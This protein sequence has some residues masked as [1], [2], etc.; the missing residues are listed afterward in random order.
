MGTYF[1][2]V[3]SIVV[4]LALTGTA[5]LLGG[6]TARAEQGAAVAIS[7]KDHRFQPAEIH[8]PAN[9]SLAI[10]V[11]N[12]DQAAMEFESVSLRVE[13]VIVPGGEGVVNIRP[14]APGKYEFFDDFHQQTRGTLVV[15]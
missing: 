8:A 7:V 1:V 5:L 11:K 12:L 15:E 4:A 14:L 3:G 6:E 9:R 13:K 10:R 2:K